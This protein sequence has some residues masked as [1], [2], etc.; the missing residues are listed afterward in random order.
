MYGISDTAYDLE[1]DLERRRWMPKWSVLTEYAPKPVG[2]YSQ[3]IV[4]DGW[5]FVSGQIAINQETGE[6]MTDDVREAVRQIL[7]QLEAILTGAGGSLADVVKT[8]IY[9]TSMDDFPA[10]NEVYGE[11]F[12][13]SLPARSCVE[14]ASLPLG[15]TV[16][17]EAIA[18]IR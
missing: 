7:R 2:A 9:L 8:T 4:A 16:E 12:R 1:L 10:V 5:L 6:P 11:Y 3:G 18:R 14:V 13:G 15:A 17:I